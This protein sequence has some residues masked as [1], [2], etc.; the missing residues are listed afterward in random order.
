MIRT[1][2]METDPTHQLPA[3]QGPR[4]TRR[5]RDP[6]VPKLGTHTVGDDQGSADR[7]D[8]PPH[9]PPWGRRF[10]I[11]LANGLDKSF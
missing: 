1:V 4:R 3:S 5:A 11:A 8:P 9:L 6:P 2:W 10:P 7:E